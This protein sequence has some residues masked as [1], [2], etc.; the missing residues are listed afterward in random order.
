MNVKVV[1]LWG[2][3]YQLLLQ[4]E[5]TRLTYNKFC[6]L[7]LGLTQVLTCSFSAPFHPVSRLITSSFQSA[8]H[9]LQLCWVSHELLFKC[10]ICCHGDCVISTH[11]CKKCPV[12]FFVRSLKLVFK[13]RIKHQRDQRECCVVNSRFLTFHRYLG[14]SREFWYKR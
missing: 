3:R 8:T 2:Y 6:A 11:P 13:L 7:A 5:N 4:S 1:S 14:P 10:D 12:L 9:A